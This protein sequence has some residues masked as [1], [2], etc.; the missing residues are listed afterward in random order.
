MTSNARIDSELE[1][2]IALFPPADLNDPI[3]ARKKLANARDQ[4]A[5][6]YVKGI[7]IEDCTGRRQSGMCRCE[8]IA[9]SRRRLPS[10]GRTAADLSWVGLETS[11]I[12]WAVRYCGRLWGGRRKIPVGYRLAPEH[13]FP[14]A[15]RMTPTSRSPG[16]SGTQPNSASSRAGSPASAATP[17]A[18]GSATAVVLRARDQQGPPI[19][20]QL[21]RASPS[22]RRLQGEWVGTEIHRGL[23][24]R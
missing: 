1:P 8:S 24:H 22:L 15:S 14:A 19:S 5:R 3:T 12:W 21:L 7:E 17:P 6:P 11:T 13:R 4:R 18:R 10:S 16:R 23:R 2:F 20:F 9:R